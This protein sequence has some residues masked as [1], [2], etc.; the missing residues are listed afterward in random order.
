MNRFSKQCRARS[1]RNVRFGSFQLCRQISTAADAKGNLRRTGGD[2]NGDGGSCGTH[3]RKAKRGA[4]RIPSPPAAPHGL[5]LPSSSPPKFRAPPLVGKQDSSCDDFSQAFVC[6]GDSQMPFQVPNSQPTYES[7]VTPLPMFDLVAQ[8][9]NHLRKWKQRWL[10]IS[11]LCDLS[12]AQWCEDTKSIVLEDQVNG[13]SNNSYR[14][15]ATL[16]EAQQEYL[17]FLKEELLEDQAI[18]DAVPLAQLPPEECTL[19]KE[20]HRRYVPGGSKITSSPS[21]SW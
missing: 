3:R 2:E 8:V 11:R 4:G 5:F 17:T 16:E 20:H 21:S 1:W 6:I 9:Y 7:K 14:G 18:D 13:Y 15:Y 10:T 12:G 19:Y